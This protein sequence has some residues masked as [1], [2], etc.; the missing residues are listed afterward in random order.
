MNRTLLVLWT[1]AL[2]LCVAGAPAGDTKPAESG[3]VI[4][5]TFSYW[6]VHITLRP[7]PFGTSEKAEPHEKGMV[8][9]NSYS[10]GS[11]VPPDRPKTP[12]P[13]DGWM[14]PEFDDA[15]W[16]RDPGP[17]WGGKDRG[18]YGI[19]RP[20]NNRWGAWQASTIALMCMRG[21]FQ[22]TDPAQVKSL[23]LAMNYRGGMV[24]YL[25]GK[26]VKRLHMRDGD[27]DMLT[28]AEDYPVE[29]TTKDGKLHDAWHVSPKEL[30][31]LRVRG[32]KDVEIPVE[33]LKKGVNV[34]AIEVH[35]AA[36]PVEMFKLSRRAAHARSGLCWNT[37]GLMDFSMTAQGSGIVSN[38]G[39]PKGLQVWNA[40]TLESVY[41][42]DYGDPNETLKPIRIVGARNGSFTGQVILGSTEP[43]RGLKAEVSDLA[44]KDGTG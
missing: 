30:I 22:V 35:R 2:C 17:Y 24:I 21:K 28:L 42:T 33:H 4:L 25:N 38:T 27:I 36:L 43:I 1:A 12:L 10:R 20:H 18:V 8:A 41:T 19:A 39:R 37:V 40:N 29:A 16:W 31:D 5:D 15:R 13:P 3:T 26:E 6:R 23:K 11:T 32:A 44:T 14:N 34:L 7:V 9:A